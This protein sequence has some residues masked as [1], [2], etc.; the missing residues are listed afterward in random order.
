MTKTS[1]P[2]GF[3]VVECDASDAN[4]ALL[5]TKEILAELE[6]EGKL[7][8][9]NLSIPDEEFR[10]YYQKGDCAL[11]AIE[12]ADGERAAYAVGHFRPYKTRRFL[13]PLQRLE[14]A[15]VSLEEIGYVYFIEV[16]KSY[17]GLGFQRALFQELETRLASR[18]AKYL[19]G[20]VSPDNAPS[21][22]NFIMSGYV[23]AGTGK[24]QSGFPRLLM[25]KKIERPTVR[26]L[27]PC[28]GDARL[29]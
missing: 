15:P 14:R 26:V 21:L 13:E 29:L 17:R 23:E 9:Y 6:A 20:T 28:P 4:A 7:G 10:D 2:V 11:L 12:A 27:E 18:G 1:L 3:S 8:Q 16:G 22:R 25:V 19:A 5:F 24:T